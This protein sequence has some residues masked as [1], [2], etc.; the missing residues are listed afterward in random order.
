MSHR[1]EPPDSCAIETGTALCPKLSERRERDRRLPPFAPPEGSRLPGR[2]SRSEALRKLRYPR[3]TLV[4]EAHLFGR[5][6]GRSRATLN[7]LQGSWAKGRGSR[8]VRRCPEAA[9]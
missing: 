9:R 2:D 3:N 4:G 5:W 7:R 1:G 6:K 8:S